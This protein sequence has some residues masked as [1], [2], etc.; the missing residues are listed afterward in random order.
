MWY[1]YQKAIT[2]SDA[3][4]RARPVNK[5]YCNAHFADV[6]PLSVT[7]ICSSWDLPVRDDSDE[8]P[9]LSFSAR[10]V[11]PATIPAEA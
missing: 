8:K 9:C 2:Y 4:R 5:P 11:E 3:D 7:R 6:R 1:S 10:K